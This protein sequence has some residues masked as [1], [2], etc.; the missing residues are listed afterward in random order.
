MMALSTETYASI[1]YQTRK[2]SLKIPTVKVMAFSSPLIF[3]YGRHLEAQGQDQQHKIEN[4]TKTHTKSDLKFSQWAASS[5]A[6]QHES[7]KERHYR[8]DQQKPTSRNQQST[9]KKYKRSR[10]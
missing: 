7:A 2:H 10:F 6:P 4:K 3:K 8:Q 1:K 9:E 5:V